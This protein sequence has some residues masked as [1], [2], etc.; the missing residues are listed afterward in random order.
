MKG[1]D[2]LLLLLRHGVKSD[3]APSFADKPRPAQRA[4]PVAGLHGPHDR[5][6]V[7]TQQQQS[8]APSKESLLDLCRQLE[9][10]AAAGAQARALAVLRTLRS[11]PVDAEMLT[12]CD[13]GKRVRSLKKAGDAAI[14]ALAGEVVEAWKQ[15]LLRA[16]GAAAESK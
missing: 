6:Q 3:K 13:V 1:S 2:K 9:V 16:N 10:Q 15:A 14:A 4:G 11:F 12:S 8:A 5:L 7:S